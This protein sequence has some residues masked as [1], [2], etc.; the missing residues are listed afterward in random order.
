MRVRWFSFSATLLLALMG[1]GGASSLSGTYMAKDSDGA[2]MLQLTENQSHQLLGSILFVT[3]Q[4][5]GGLEKRVANITGGSTDG[6]SLTVTVKANQLFSQPENVGGRVASGG[7]DLTF[8]T[9]IAH[10][11]SASPQAFDAAVSELAATGQEQQRRRDL[12]RLTHDLN[13]YC[14]KMD[15]HPI[16]KERAHDEE[17]KLVAAAQHDLT[18]ERRLSPQS[19]QAGQVRY[20]IRNLDFQLGQI[21]FKVVRAEPVWHA[22][23]QR[24]NAR[25]AANPCNTTKHLPGCDAFAAAEQRY[26]SVRTRVLGDA[27]Q[28]EADMQQ[29]KSE[30]ASLNKEAG[31]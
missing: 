14:A 28:V 22:E 11:A 18:L 21:G 2:V 7:I 31:N 17:Q 15:A 29:S 4:R 27:S 30:M 24:L 10:F 19:F 16:T 26:T 5:N 23:I 1:C 3:L 13:A 12:A 6:S 8:G 9:V 20:R 25:A